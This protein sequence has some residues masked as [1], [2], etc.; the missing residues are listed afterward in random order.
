MKTPNSFELEYILDAACQHCAEKAREHELDAIRHEHF[1]SV[2]PATT[3]IGPQKTR[4]ELRTEALKEAAKYR[5]LAE[6][7]RE[8]REVAHEHSF[9]SLMAQAERIEKAKQR[10]PHEE[11]AKGGINQTSSL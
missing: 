2:P 9:A 1:A 4:A 8:M 7:A 10:A 6:A 11:D 5:R 3:R